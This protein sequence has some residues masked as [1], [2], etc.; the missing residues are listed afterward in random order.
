MSTLHARSCAELGG[1]VVLARLLVCV[2]L[3]SA[4][5]VLRSSAPHPV[6]TLPFLHAHPAKVDQFDHDQ[7]GAVVPGLQQAVR[8]CYG[9]R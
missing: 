8:R 6:L 1:V 7:A 4:P 5:L 3:S 9:Q 2:L